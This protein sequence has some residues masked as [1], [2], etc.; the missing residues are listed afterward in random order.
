MLQYKILSPH[1]IKEI[2]GLEGTFLERVYEARSGLIWYDLQSG[3]G[4][5][6]MALRRARPPVQILQHHSISTTRIRRPSHAQSP[7]KQGRP[8]F[9]FCTSVYKMNAQIDFLGKLPLKPADDT[10]ASF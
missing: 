6:I 3:P 5:S 9:Y 4:K 2:R 8:F 7:C 1:F 10:L